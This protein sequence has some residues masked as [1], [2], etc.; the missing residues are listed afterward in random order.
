[1]FGYVFEAFYLDAFVE[2]PDTDGFVFG[3]GGYL[4]VMGGKFYATDVVLVT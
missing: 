2:V 1:M 4:G 3:A